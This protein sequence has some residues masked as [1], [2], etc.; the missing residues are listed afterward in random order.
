M[1]VTKLQIYLTIVFLGI[2]YL[3]AFSYFTTQ[4][5][6]DKGLVRSIQWQKENQLRELIFEVSQ[7]NRELEQQLRQ[8]Q[9]RVSEEE[10]ILSSLQLNSPFLHQE[11]DKYRFMA[12]LVDAQGPGLI[13]TLDDSSFAAESAAVH[14][15]IIHEQDVR[16]LV[17]ELLAAGAEGISINGQRVIHSTAIRCVGPTIIV[18][19]VKSSAPFV[20]SAIGDKHTLLNALTMPDGI[21]DMLKLWDIQ[22]VIEQTEQVFLPAYLGEF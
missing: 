20:I 11:L 9:Q 15:F 12:G 1:K 6:E 21:V 4:E 8:I 16:H 19:K 3:F 22:V 13:V 18:N 5:S 7:Q 17:N 10:R 2:G 14:P